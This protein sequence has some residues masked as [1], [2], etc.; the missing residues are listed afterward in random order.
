[1]QAHT[2]LSKPAPRVFLVT[3]AHPD[4]R[5][6]AHV[7]DILLAAE[8]AF[9][10]QEREQRFIEGPAFGPLADVQDYMRHAVDFYHDRVQSLERS[11]VEV[12]RQRRMF[13]NNCR[14]QL[15]RQIRSTPVTL[16]T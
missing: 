8:H 13:P 7:I 11:F 4:G 10:P 14:G 16:G 12:A 9:Q 1:M 3:G 5:P 15:R 2:S 6:S